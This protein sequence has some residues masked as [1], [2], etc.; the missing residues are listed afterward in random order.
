MVEHLPHHPIVNG[1]N[2]TTVAGTGRDKLQKLFLSFN[3]ITSVAQ[4][5]N[6]SLITS[7]L[8]VHVQAFL[9]TLGMESGKQMF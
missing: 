2:L 9:L 6:A 5:K 7:R 4:W 1:L 3:C 8:R